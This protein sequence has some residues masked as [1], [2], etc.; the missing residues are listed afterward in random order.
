M[1]TPG[2]LQYLRMV[3]MADRSAFRPITRAQQALPVDDRLGPA[4]ERLCKGAKEPSPTTP[5]A[6]FD[7]SAIWSLGGKANGC[8]KCAGM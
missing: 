5:A 4:D 6:V 1:N 7:L 2:S 8:I 3:L